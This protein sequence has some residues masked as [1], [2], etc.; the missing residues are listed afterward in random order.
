LFKLGNKS[1]TSPV[2]IKD[3]R[4]TSLK[5]IAFV[6]A[7]GLHQS[8]AAQ[9][10]NN[11]SLSENPVVILDDD[12]VVAMMDSLLILHQNLN[13]AFHPNYDEP[14]YNFPMD[15]VPDF[16]DSV[17]IERIKCLDQET[18]FEMRY[19]ET[20]QAFI[21][22]YAKRRRRYTQVELGLT[23][24]F[25]P[26]YE[27]MLD[28]YNMPLELKYLSIV[29][30][31]L[32][33]RAKS[34]S[35][36]MGLWQFM[37]PTGKMY[38]L[39]VTSYIDE[40][41][42]PYKATVAACKYLSFL[43]SLYDDW[44]MALAAYNAGPGTVGRAIRRSG[45]KKTYWEIRE[46]LPKETRS[47][48]PAFIAVN[49]VMSHAREH[50]LRPTPPDRTFFDYDTVHIKHG[51]T[52]NQISQTI[53][54]PI[55]ELE[56]LNPVYKTHVVPHTI[57]EE[58]YIYLPKDKVGDFL[59]NEET[60]YNYKKHEE[61]VAE[62]TTTEEKKIHVVRSGEYLGLIANKY[63]CTIAEVKKWNKLSSMNIHSGQKLVVYAKT[64]VPVKSTGEKTTTA[65]NKTPEKKVT[66][67][68]SDF[69][70]YTIQKGD[71]LWDIANK[72]KG[73]SV[74]EIRKWN[75]QLNEKNLQTGQKVKIGVK[76]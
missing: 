64:K 73:V 27:E 3:M 49:Y 58:T 43:H 59:V 71:T 2:F 10:S 52:F 62:F 67:A 25:F 18:P 75:Q 51:L 60:I 41:K 57:G 17:Y 5:A 76:G 47:Y 21:N 20:V 56:Q 50:N 74:D 34:P 54:I 35:G 69:T 1:P 48:V 55:K 7:C 32:N 37:Y 11:D 15:S 4:N 42:D 38:G 9:L 33:P 63:G 36:A 6:L 46:F 66:S 23:E 28:K 45:G 39:R 61:A 24:V 30:S 53:G 26:M 8:N 68:S 19:N 40:R 14:G 12:P 22:L 29:E 72:Y 16:P 13:Y 65:S 70:Y 44:S 31:G